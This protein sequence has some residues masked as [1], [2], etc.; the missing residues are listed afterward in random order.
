MIDM[1]SGLLAEYGINKPF[2]RQ[3]KTEADHDLA[4]VRQ[5]CRRV[6]VVLDGK[7]VEHGFIE[8]VIGSPQHPYTHGLVAS[9]RL[10]FGVKL[11]FIFLPLIM[12]IKVFFSTTSTR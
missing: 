10:L 1:G 12:L 9:A 2:S 6:M 8:E 3:H 11:A 4:V 7:I 5:V